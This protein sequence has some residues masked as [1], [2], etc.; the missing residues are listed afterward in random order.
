MTN[1]EPKP[2]ARTVWAYAYEFTQ[3]Q[4]ADK[5]HAVQ[6]LLDREETE[7]RK[8]S[9]SWGS[10]F[11][12]KE[13][14]T[15]ILVVN[16]S[17]RQDLKVNRRL[18]MELGEMKRVSPSPQPWPSTKTMRRCRRLWAWLGAPGSDGLVMAGAEEWLFGLGRARPS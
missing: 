7:A 2:G 1:K 8:D 5:M 17:P 14:V 10:R 18:E 4:P 12:T 13:Q 3:P 11:V 15:H 16:D 6:G 9:R